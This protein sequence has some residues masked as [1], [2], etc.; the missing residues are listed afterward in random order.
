L[1][2]VDSIYF[3]L[4]DASSARPLLFNIEQFQKNT[5]GTA[6]AE[7]KLVAEKRTVIARVRPPRCDLVICS[8]YVSLYR[9][10][11]AHEAILQLDLLVDCFDSFTDSSVAFL[12]G[13]NIL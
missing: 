4:H 1:A 12:R 6:A 7:S 5:Y 11:L 3:K 13:I 8:A 10:V 9:L 2:R